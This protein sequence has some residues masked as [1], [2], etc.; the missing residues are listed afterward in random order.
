[1]RVGHRK[2]LAMM[3]SASAFLFLTAFAGV[4]TDTQNIVSQVEVPAQ[5]VEAEV[6]EVEVPETIEAVTETVTVTEAPVE[7]TK[8]TVLEEAE[9][10]VEW[11]TVV[12]ANVQESLNIRAEASEESEIVGKLYAGC[13]GSLL[14]KKDGWTKISSGEVVGYVKDEYVLVGE[15][16]KELADAKGNLMVEVNTETLRVREDATEEAKVLGLVAADDNLVVADK[17]I[18][19]GWIKVDFDDAQGY[20]SLDYVN[21]EYSFGSAVTIEEELA[22]QAAV[23]AEAAGAT[24]GEATSLSSDDVTLLA[25]MIQCEAGNECFEGKVAVG[26]VILNRVNSG[27]YPSSIYG[28]ITAPGQFPPATNGTLTSVMAR[29]ISSD[30]IKAAQTAMSGVN[31]VGSAKHFRSVSSGY[32][33]TVIGNHVFW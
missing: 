1:M 13:K 23:Q 32:T 27:S 6:Q 18:K 9:N 11:E 28:V 3:S 4:A 26:N 33:G 12:L 25:A 17:E 29:G 5:T 2:L 8:N 22:A 31:Y 7:E 21:V 24:Q 16:A 10:S 19:D 20:V 14:E 15:P 30:C